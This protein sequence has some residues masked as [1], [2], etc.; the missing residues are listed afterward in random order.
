[1]CLG[2]TTIPLSGHWE[3][4]RFELIR[5]SCLIWTALSAWSET[6]AAIEMNCNV[7]DNVLYNY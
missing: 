7:Y 1:M 6:S 5:Y 3:R 4:E 2:E